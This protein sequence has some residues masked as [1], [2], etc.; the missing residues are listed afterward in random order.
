MSAPVLATGSEQF[1]I[2]LFVY[3][4]YAKTEIMNLEMVSGEPTL[5]IYKVVKSLWHGIKQIHLSSLGNFTE[6]CRVRNSFNANKSLFSRVKCNQYGRADEMWLRSECECNDI[7]SYIL[8]SQPVLT[9]D[10]F[11]SLKRGPNQ[12]IVA[13]SLYGT[14]VRYYNLLQDLVLK[15]QKLYTDHVIRIYHDNSINRSMICHYECSYRHV[16]FCNIHKLPLQLTDPKKVLNIDYIHS[17]MWRFLPI[18]DTFVDLFM[19]RDLDSDLLQ[20]EIDS[21]QEWLSSN[22]IGHIM[23]DNPAHGTYILGGM[24]SF[25]TSKD[26]NLGKEIFEDIIN[27]NSSTKFKPRGISVK[28]YDQHFLSKHVYPRIKDKSTIHDS[29]LCKKYPKSKPWPTQRKGNCFV[30]RV[31]RCNET[32][33]FKPCPKECRPHDHLDWKYSQENFLS[34]QKLMV[35]LDRSKKNK[36]D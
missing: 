8:N 33:V 6:N 19:S 27:K 7:K 9:C 26:R 3:L 2:L 21:V 35:A 14:N 12:K 29:Y 32:G 25:K 11:K 31:G 13:F 28:G 15:V 10:L 20:R 24:W 5:S 1:T 36:V 23:R 34:F 18:G 30:G 16:E 4:F 17:M 22:N